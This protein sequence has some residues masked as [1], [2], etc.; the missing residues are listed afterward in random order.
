MN[1]VLKKIGYS[2]ILWSLIISINQTS[3]AQTRPKVNP[4]ANSI[5]FSIYEQIGQEITTETLQSILGL[6]QE[7][8][9]HEYT[10]IHD[11]H[12][13][14]IYEF[15]KERFDIYSALFITK[16]SLRLA[17]IEN[18]EMHIA[19][20]YTRLSQYN[21][22]IG[23]RKKSMIYLDSTITLYDQLN[24]PQEL[25][26]VK[27]WKL[28]ELLKFA[29]KDSIFGKMDALL[30]ETKTANDPQLEFIVLK[31]IIGPKINFGRYKEVETHLDNLEQILPKAFTNSVPAGQIMEFHRN[32]GLLLFVTNKL[33]EAKKHYA[34]A[35]HFSIL[36]PDR[37]REVHCYQKL[38]TI[39][40]QL[41]N[42]QIAKVYLDSAFV[43]ANQLNVHDLHIV[44]HDLNIIIAEE[45]GRY[46]EALRALRQKNYH[47]E[48]LD[49]AHAGF[50]VEKYYLQLEKDQLII[51]KENRDLQLSSRKRQVTYSSIIAL[52]FLTLAGISALAFFNQR[53]KRK[54]LAQQNELILQQSNK[55]AQL[56][57]TKSRFFTNVSHELRTPLTLILGPIG[58]LIKNGDLNTK[59]KLLLKKAQENTKILLKLVSSILDLSKIESNKIIL[60]ESEVL[61][62]PFFKRLFSTFETYAHQQQ[63]KFS[64]HYTLDKN[65]TL[66]LDVEKLETIIVN[67][68]SNAMKFTQ[69]KGQVSIHVKDK[70]KRIEIWVSD[71]G[72]GIH[73]DD[74]DHVFDRYYQSEQPNALAEGGTGI[75]LA[76]S[77]ELVEIMKGKIWVDSVWGLGS[78]FFLEIPKTEVH[79]ISSTR[80]K[81][82]ETPIEANEDKQL[83]EKK[84]SILSTNPYI[85]IVEDNLHLREYLTSILS[86]YY[87]VIASKN[88]LEALDTLQEAR[89]CQLIISD[90]MMPELDGFQL[91][92]MLKSRD[93]YRHIPI[94]ILTASTDNKDKMNALRIGIDD[95]LLKPFEEEELLTRINNLLNNQSERTTL[96][97]TQTSNEQEH[98]II[99]N[100]PNWLH[101]LESYVITHINNKELSS[102]TIAHNFSMSELTLIH[103]LKKQTGL[104][105]DKYI[106]DVRLE[107]ARSILEMNTFSSIEQIAKEVGFTDILY[108]SRSFKQRH[109]KSVVS[110]FN[111]KQKTKHLR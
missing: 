36:A 27:M 88:G 81:M 98:A 95:Y 44:N 94:I 65:L 82:I 77:K 43:K 28:E 92:S 24:H 84:P 60:N 16:K 85:L 23:N 55:L 105:L 32:K 93:Y 46:Q 57:K 21:G 14:L 18:N 2:F 66:V 10:C 3:Y 42:R 15:E 111:I 86:Q 38:T 37:W 100:N 50:N 90:I 102:A 31:N 9:N 79:T 20:F 8:C 87:T 47:T 13:K 99:E 106:E 58:H 41:G 70:N 40:W 72:R 51:E 78:T 62:F 69:S 61:L 63:I 103:H 19:D 25:T 91:V 53:K 39:E 35:L 110:F 52:L 17:Q 71:T 83:A 45:E 76:L 64:L 54:A 7:K 74:I 68:L 75:G 34:L 104:S 33:E 26:R 48:E 6:V 1:K 29:D 59:D 96:L 73:L 56:D 80:N 4:H 107:T 101:E 12:R 11:I 108:F 30:N 22:A 49:K 89:Q 67:L 109:G 97:E 5:W